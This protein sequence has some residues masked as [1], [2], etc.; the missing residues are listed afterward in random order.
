MRWRSELPSEQPRG[1]V[2]FFTT[3]LQQTQATPAACSMALKSSTHPAESTGPQQKC[4]LMKLVRLQLRMA[5]TSD[6]DVFRNRELDRNN[7]TKNRFAGSTAN[8][9]PSLPEPVPLS[10]SALAPLNRQRCLEMTW[11][12]SGQCPPPRKGSASLASSPS[13]KALAYYS[14]L[15]AVQ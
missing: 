11:R 13:T 6:S 10:A 5:Q 9:P 3:E 7:Y 4:T 12:L 14:T 1:G 2:P 15:Q 8:K